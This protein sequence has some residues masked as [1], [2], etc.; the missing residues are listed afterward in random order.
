[1]LALFRNGLSRFR[2]SSIRST[3]VI[4]A[5]ALSL[6]ACG[7]GDDGFFGDANGNGS[8][9]DEIQFTIDYMQKNY[10]WANELPANIN[11]DDYSDSFDALTKLRVPQD[12]FSNIADAAR[13]TA[14]YQG[15]L[16]GF[17]F[18]F[19]YE[20]DNIRL[21]LVQPNSP[22]Y[23]AGLRRNDV[24]TEINSKSPGQWRAEDKIDEAFGPT[25]I[26]IQRTFSIT[27]TAG[28]STKTIT[29]DRYDI[30]YVPASGIF[31]Q[32]IRKIGYIH[33]YSYADPGVA[34]WNDVISTLVAQGAQDLIVDLRFNGGGLISTAAQ[35]GSALGT[36]SLNNRIM[37]SLT[38][39]AQNSSDNRTFYFN[40]HPQSGKFENLVWLTSENTCSASEA[41]I[42]GIKPW[43]TSTRIGETTCGKPYGFTPP[44][45]N[46][47]TFNIVSFRLE[48]A[49]GET[50]YVDGLAPD[51]AVVDTGAGELGQADEVLT[52]AALDFLSTGTCPTASSTTTAK[53]VNQNNRM[54]LK[55][56]QN[57]SNVY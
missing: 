13:T 12:K 36:A 54:E 35:V 46:D 39:N 8:N 27:N 34:P 29:K 3:T 53:S 19:R 30:A 5:I 4:G 14:F 55:G 23:A 38:F 1:M 47:K 43:R 42:L 52:A 17:G 16:V 15:Q 32:G 31:T 6:S 49:N 25:E 56:L 22:A 10:L 20:G 26:G 50:D 2:S 18:N 51:C 7:G 48:N 33:F 44:T 37:T 28:T 21:F 9:R 45:F 40:D 11:I 41:M 24:I 57:L